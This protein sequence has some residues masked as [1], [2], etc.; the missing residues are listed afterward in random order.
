MKTRQRSFFLTLVSIVAIGTFSASTNNTPATPVITV[1]TS[2]NPQSTSIKDIRAAM[3][4]TDLPLR[5][6]VWTR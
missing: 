4:L 5:S 2:N 6:N 1:Q 3:G